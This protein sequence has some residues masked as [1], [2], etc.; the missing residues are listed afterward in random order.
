MLWGDIKPEMNARG[1]LNYSK[2]HRKLHVV[3]VSKEQ[4]ISM[5]YALSILYKSVK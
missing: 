1:W 3:N 2:K 5:H 4:V